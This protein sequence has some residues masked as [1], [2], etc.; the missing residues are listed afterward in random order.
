MAIIATF[1]TESMVYLLII[2][3]VY[4]FIATPIMPVT[5][6]FLVEVTFP[7]P[8]HFTTGIIFSTG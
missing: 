5:M 3:F 1:Y 6:D 2:S 7:V 4:G 8:E